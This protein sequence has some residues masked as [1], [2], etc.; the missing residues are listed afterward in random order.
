MPA[1]GKLNIEGQAPIKLPATNRLKQQIV[2]LVT[3]K[4]H[5][6]GFNM[7]GNARI[8]AT[9]AP[10]KSHRYRPN[11]KALVAI[12]R[13]LCPHHRRLPGKPD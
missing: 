6:T 5:P 10:V 7:D 9:E 3:S 4:L 1:T 8:R 13:H 12:K 11:K 2:N